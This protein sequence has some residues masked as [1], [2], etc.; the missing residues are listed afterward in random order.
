[1][2]ER[3]YK[4]H[5]GAGVTA[6]QM[7]AVTTGTSIKTMQ[8]LATPATADL[9]IVAWGVIHDGHASCTS[10]SVELLTCATGGATVTAYAAGDITGMNEAAKNLASNVVISSTTNGGYTS[11][12]ENTLSAVDVLDSVYLVPTQADRYVMQ[13]PLGR[14]PHVAISRWVRI[15]VTAAGNA[16]NMRTWIEWGE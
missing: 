1:M 8:Q 9:W 12:G 7:L 5:N 2:S 15:R 3:L 6:A 16:T 11:G 4:A 13:W 14:E 10:M